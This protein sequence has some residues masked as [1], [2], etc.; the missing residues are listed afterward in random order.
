MK[1]ATDACEEKALIPSWHGV[2]PKEK[3]KHVFVIGLAGYAG[4]GKTTLA[5]AIAEE[6]GGN[7]E[8][9]IGQRWSFSKPLKEL[10]SVLL[11]EADMPIEAS[12]PRKRD[13]MKA[14]PGASGIS[15]SVSA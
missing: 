13:C 9:P 3:F 11:K 2:Y 6:L 5:D 8:M 7:S 14:V 15:C 4:A 10:T 1:E 12:K